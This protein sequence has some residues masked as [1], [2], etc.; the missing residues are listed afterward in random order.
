LV[1]LGVSP[2][3]LGYA[4]AR[5][6]IVATAAG[7]AMIVLALRVRV[8]VRGHAASKQLFAFSILY[9]FLLF[10]TLLADHL[11]GGLAA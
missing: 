10:A 8:E 2:W 4:S 7:A 3:L 11:S 5:Y 6:G 9:L 1:P